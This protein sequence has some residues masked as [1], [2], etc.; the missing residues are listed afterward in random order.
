MSQTKSQIANRTHYLNRCKELRVYLK[1]AETV[2]S[3]IIATQCLSVLRNIYGSKWRVALWVAKRA[4]HDSSNTLKAKV[5][6]A[7]QRYVRLRTEEEIQKL[8]DEHLE[9]KWK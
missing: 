5:W 8:I 3:H 7:W 6:R 4:A 1:D 2:P 9:K